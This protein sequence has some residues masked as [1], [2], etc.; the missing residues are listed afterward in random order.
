MVQL[1]LRTLPAA[2]ALIGVLL[3]A[4]CGAV[5]K[6]KRTN[7]LQAATHGYQSA[8][9]WGYY[10]TAFGY[11]HPDQRKDKAVPE[12][13]EGLRLT[14]YDVVQPPVM[15]DEDSATQVVRIDYL[16]EDTQVVKQLVDRQ[17]WR[18]DDKLESWWLHSGLPKFE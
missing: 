11:L 1:V 4:G 3:L 12:S 17:V 7:G 6:D 15:Q 8:I 5:E 2:G 10:E 16:H 18:W 13:L 14:G 9:R